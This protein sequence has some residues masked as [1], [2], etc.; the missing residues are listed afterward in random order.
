MRWRGFLFLVSG[1]AF[2]ATPPVPP[3]LAELAAKAGINGPLA[4][5]C[6]GEFRPGQRGAFAVAAGS[7]R[8]G[9]RYLVVESDG[10]AYQLSAYAG[11]ADIACYTPAEAKKLN[12]TIGETDTVHG[13]VG[14]RWSTTVVCGFVEDTEAVCWQYSPAEARFV[15]VGG[16]TT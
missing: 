13:K 16:W 9:G 12:E 1:V 2:A 8:K 10:K 11:G 5:W 4:G 7:A 14:P 6:G 3:A 15:K